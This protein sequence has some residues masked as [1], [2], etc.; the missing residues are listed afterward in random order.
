MNSPGEQENHVGFTEG[1]AYHQVLP[2]GIRRYLNAQR[3]IRN[4]VI[5]LHLLGWN[6]QCITIPVFDR[7][8]QF[9][10]FKL[11]KDP[12]DKSDSPKMLASPGAHAELY[13]WE[14]VN[15]R[16]R[17]IIICEGEFD[18][19]V[20]E[21]HGFPTVTSTAGARVFR[22]D[23]ANALQGIPELFICFDRDQAGR[24]GALN[25]A[26]LLPKARVI[27]LP[28]EVGPGGDATDFFARLGH[29][30]G[31]FMA[32]M[33]KARPIE[34]EDLGTGPEPPRGP[35]D[36]IAERSAGQI[37]RVKQLGPITDVISQYVTLRPSGKAF[38]GL[39]P[40]HNDHT[41]S[42]AVY[43]KTGTFYC[44]GC[45]KHGDALAFLMEKERLS[46]AEALKA[47]SLAT[48]NHGQQKHQ[49]GR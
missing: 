42:L 39:C 2:T 31:E 12:Q 7:Q 14:Q 45:Q 4:D 11:A 9:A 30:G 44:F 35:S 19:L 32:L 21:S 43:P 41:P 25:V 13:G 40:F 37:N 46:F 15:R 27:E 3:G 29:G 8:G 26:R 38:M 33:E 48:P 17:Q 1:H 10:F 49:R 24:E 22:Q 34:P 18:R 28:E 47:L 5:D 20:V 36:G 23:W 6:G 16:P